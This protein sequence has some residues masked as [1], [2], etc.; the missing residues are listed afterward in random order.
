MDQIDEHNVL[1]PGFADLVMGHGQLVDGMGPPI[2][3]DDD[4]DDDDEY[5]DEDDEDE[6]HYSAGINGKLPCQYNRFNS[7][8]RGDYEKTCLSW[9]GHLLGESQSYGNAQESKMQGVFVGNDEV[10]E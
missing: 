4:M 3:D 8:L 6:I 7:C 5:S 1:R 10:E 9:K 2:F